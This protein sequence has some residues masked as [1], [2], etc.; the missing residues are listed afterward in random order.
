MFIAQYNNTKVPKMSDKQKHTKTRL[1]GGLQL[2][3][4]GEPVILGPFRDPHAPRMPKTADISAGV[5]GEIDK[6]SPVIMQKREGT[7]EIVFTGENTLYLPNIIEQKIN[8]I[9]ATNT[10]QVTEFINTEINDIVLQDTLEH[11]H[12]A[13]QLSE[14][15]QPLQNLEIQ[16]LNSNIEVPGGNTKQ[17]G[18]Y[19]T[20]HTFEEQGEMRSEELIN[21]LEIEIP[22]NATPVDLEYI[23]DDFALDRPVYEF[24]L[25]TGEAQLYESGQQ[26]YNGDIEGAIKHLEEKWGEEINKPYSTVKVQSSIQGTQTK[27]HEQAQ[28][29]LQ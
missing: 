25:K 3:K 27:L 4:Q 9:E 10:E 28:K 26:I 13:S 17:Y 12:Q 20:L 23:E 11:Y 6:Y 1:G 18:D 8:N 7:Q 29:F 16:Y 22:E 21:H 19:E 5:M 14:H 24:N 2:K 15:L